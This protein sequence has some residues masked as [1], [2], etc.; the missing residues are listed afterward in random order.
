MNSNLIEVLLGHPFFFSIPKRLCLDLGMR[1]PDIQDTSARISILLSWFA[2]LTFT[3]LSTSICQVTK[4]TSILPVCQVHCA[5]SPHLNFTLL[6]NQVQSPCHLKGHIANLP[7][8][9]HLVNL[10]QCA[11][12]SSFIPSL[13]TLLLKKGLPTSKTFHGLP[14]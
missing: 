8:P 6:I 7:S 1:I 13:P 2:K 12:S 11:S 5:K 9:F 3:C 10:P 14:D 4:S